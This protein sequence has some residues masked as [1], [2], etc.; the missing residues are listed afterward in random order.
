MIEK[1]TNVLLFFRQ[2]EY[3]QFIYL[4]I[5]IILKNNISPIC[6]GREEES[7]VAVQIK[8]TIW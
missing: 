5:L 4:K 6:L 1:F 3:T 8:K 7:S 2:K